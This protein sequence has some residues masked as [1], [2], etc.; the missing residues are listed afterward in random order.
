MEEISVK[1]RFTIY[2]KELLNYVSKNGILIRFPFSRFTDDQINDSN[3][4]NFNYSSFGEAANDWQE[5]ATDNMGQM[6]LAKEDESENIF[7]G[8]CKIYYSKQGSHPIEAAFIG[9]ELAALKPTIDIG[10]STE[11]L[12]KKNN[13]MIFLLTLVSLFLAFRAEFKKS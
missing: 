3:R 2:D 6:R 11:L 8:T 9:K 4:D 5:I 13:D 1:V 12:G 10:S 7:S